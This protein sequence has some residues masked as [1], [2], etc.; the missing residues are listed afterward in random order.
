MEKLAQRRFSAARAATIN[1]GTRLS[2]RTKG[3]NIE[4]TWIPPVQFP[5]S[6]SILPFRRGNP[7]PVGQSGDYLALAFVF[8]R[9]H[10]K[11]MTPIPPVDHEPPVPVLVG[12]EGVLMPLWM[13]QAAEEHFIPEGERRCACCTSKV[14]EPRPAQ[15]EARRTNESDGTCGCLLRKEWCSI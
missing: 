2:Q 3:R 4:L 13:Y 5:S 1:V 12:V 15:C 10:K 9:R 8:L 14:G 7:A 11:D 6:L